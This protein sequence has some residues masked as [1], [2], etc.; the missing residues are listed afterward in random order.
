MSARQPKP[1]WPRRRDHPYTM[2]PLSY[3]DL[4]PSPKFREFIREKR[5]APGGGNRR[6][7]DFLS[8]WSF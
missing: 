8:P 1:E 6:L 4:K 7:I 5:G 3:R 2:P